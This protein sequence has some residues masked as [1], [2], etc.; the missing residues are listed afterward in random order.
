ME[1]PIYHVHVFVSMTG[2]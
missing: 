2:P 1:S